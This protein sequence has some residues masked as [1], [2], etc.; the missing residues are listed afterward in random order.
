MIS[1][2]EKKEQLLKERELSL[3]T[4][5]G[6]KEKLLKQ[7]ESDL[8]LDIDKK[9]KLLK[10]KE[11]QL[12]QKLKEFEHQ[13]RMLEQRSKELEQESRNLVV[14][15]NELQKREKLMDSLKKQKAELEIDIKKKHD[16]LADFNEKL[17][18]TQM[19][20]EQ[21][22]KDLDIKTKLLHGKSNQVNLIEKEVDESVN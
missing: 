7:K 3:F 11:S 21:V 2:I 17:K 20:L 8:L 9:E 15:E 6:K 16:I 10:Q 1:S 14:K 12:P 22:Q 19:G 13:S 5:L 18:I 4:D